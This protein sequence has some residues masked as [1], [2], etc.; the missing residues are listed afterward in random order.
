[1]RNDYITI[2]CKVQVA[3]IINIAQITSKES[4]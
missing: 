3:N 2:V 1:M 4:I